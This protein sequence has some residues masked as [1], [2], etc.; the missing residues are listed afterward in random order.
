MLSQI[1]VNAVVIHKMQFIYKNECM[2]LCTWLVAMHNQESTYTNDSAPPT[3]QMGRQE[4]F[5]GLDAG[6]LK[7]LL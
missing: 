6:H 2:P 5:T 7:C 4:L 3:S 1:H